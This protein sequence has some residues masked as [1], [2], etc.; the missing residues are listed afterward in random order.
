MT[1]AERRDRANETMLERGG[2]HAEEPGKRR[3]TSRDALAWTCGRCGQEQPRAAFREKPD[4]TLHSYC[5]A[6]DRAYKRQRAEANPRDPRRAHDQHLRRTY[7][8]T[9][10]EYDAIHE[11]QHGR[12]AIC[13]RPE[14]QVGGRLGNAPLR[15]VVDH[16]HATGAVRGLLCSSCNQGIGYFKHDPT[17]L[18]AAI[19]YLHRTQA[20]V[21][22]P[23]TSE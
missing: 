6:C 4:G 10:A 3:L 2:D 11:T 13:Q 22:V 16:D 8:I 21:G 1:A 12:C 14:T 7:G 19:A 20:M 18:T 23:S 9:L 5:R 15:L 17:L